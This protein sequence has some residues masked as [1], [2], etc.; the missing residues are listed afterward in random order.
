[1]INLDSVGRV[2][3]RVE[4]AVACLALVVIVGA[5]AI[6]VVSRSFFN[7]PVI[8]TSEMALLAQ[9]W[10]TFIGASAIYKSRGHVGVTGVIEAMPPFLANIV[11]R[12]LDGA[13]AILLVLAGLAMLD[14][15]DKQWEQT[16][17]TLGLPRAL[18]SLPVVWCMFSI[19]ASA[20]LAMIGSRRSSYDAGP[21]EAI[22]K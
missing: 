18:T 11:A 9:V 1:M 7:S 17:S 3:Q 4:I 12:A 5:T 15:M 6:G 20:L 10:L 13:L 22:S 19:A 16:L 21:P 8:W 2:I 14:L